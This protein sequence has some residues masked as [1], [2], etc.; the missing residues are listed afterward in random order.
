MSKRVQTNANAIKGTQVRRSGFKTKIHAD[1]EMKAFIDELIEKGKSEPAILKE[2]RN[3][4]GDRAPS[5]QPLKN[6]VERYYPVEHFIPHH[7][8][9]N[10]ALKRFDAYSKLVELAEE[11]WTRY[12][13]F[14]EREMSM[15]IPNMVIQR[16]LLAYKDVLTKMIDIEIKIGVRQGTVAPNVTLNQN[17]SVTNNISVNEERLD[18]AISDINELIAIEQTLSSYRANRRTINP[19]DIVEGEVRVQPESG[20]V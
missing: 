11:H 3:K 13:V 16:E 7:L 10:E 8:N 2:V 9:Y 1:P 19:E 6:Y 12:Q 17:N 18:N 15:K 4:F 20:Q 5:S 14:K